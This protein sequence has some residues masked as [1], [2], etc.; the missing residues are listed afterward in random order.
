[1]SGIYKVEKY[2]LLGLKDKHGLL[3]VIPISPV[4]IDIKHATV[5]YQ[6]SKNCVKKESGIKGVRFLSKGQ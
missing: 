3:M 5:K 6:L 4:F 1:M 2:F